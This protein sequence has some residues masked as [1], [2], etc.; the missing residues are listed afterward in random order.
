MARFVHLH[1]HTDLSL[2]DGACSIGAVLETCARH[3]M[4]AVAVT[5][6]GN[7][8]CAVDFYRAALKKSIR[9]IIGYEAYI[10][11]DSRR[12]R[13]GG[14]QDIRHLTLLARSSRGYKN[15]MRLA[16]CAYLEGFYYKPRI[17]YDLLAEASE[18]LIILSGCTKSDIAMRLLA[19]DHEGAERVA[20]RLMDMVGPEHFFIELQ[21]HGLDDEKAY[22]PAAVALARRLGVGLVATNDVHYISREDAEAQEV[23][24][25][26]NTGKVFSDENRMRLGTQEFYLKSPQE[27][28]AL[29][30]DLPEAVENTVRIAEMCHAE[31]DMNTTYL[32]RFRSDDGVDSDTLFRLLCEDGARRRYQDF[33]DDETLNK[34]LHH[35]MKVIHRMGFVDYF[36]VVWDFVR[37]AKANR[38][39]VGPGRGS[40]AGSMVAY[41]LGITDID[42]IRHGLLFERFLNPDRISLPDIDIDFSPEG[43]ERVIG[44]V[45]ERYG[46]DSV[47]QIITFGTLQARAAIRDVGR[48]LEIPLPQVDA[49]AKRIPP[50]TSLRKALK[51]GEDLRALA[52]DEV[53]AKLF[54]ISQRLEGLCRHASKHAAGVVIADGPLVE[55]SPLY[56][57]DG[58]IITQYA[59]GALE[60][61][62]LMKMDFLGLTTLDVIKHCTEALAADGEEVDLDGNDD[63]KTYDLLCRG[64]TKGVFQLESEGMR[65]LLTQ[66]KPRRFAE[67]V[68]VLALYRPGPMRSGMVQSYVKR[69]AGLE[70]IEYPHPSLREVLEDTYGVVLYQEQVMRIANILAGFSMSEADY[71][72]K[73]MGKKMMGIVEEHRE[74]FIEGAVARKVKKDLAE[75]IYDQLARFAEYGFNK[76]HSA[77]YAVLS[78]RTAYLK[79]NHPL[80]FTAALLSSEIGKSEKVAEYVNDCRESGLKLL[81]PDVNRSAADFRVDDGGVRYG[82][83]AIKGVGTKAAEVVVAE[84]EKNGSY[85][86]LWEFCERVDLRAVNRQVLDA[87]VKAGAMDG[88]GGHRAAL[89]AVLDRALQ[90]GQ[91]VQRDVRRGQ[92]ALFGGPG[93]A[94]DAPPPPLPDVPP[95][96]DVQ[97]MAWEKE[98]LGVYLADHPLQKHERLLSIFATHT[99][100][101]LSSAPDKH[102]VVLGVVLE[103]VLQRR[104]KRGDT[105]YQVQ[106]ADMTGGVGGVVFSRTAR[107]IGDMLKEDE[108]VFVVGSVDA[109]RDRPSVVVDSIIR[110]EEV[111]ERLNG[112]L[113]LR[114]VNEDDDSVKRLRRVLE[115]HRG[116]TVVRLIIRRDDAEYVIRLPSRFSVRPDESFFEALGRLDCVR[117]EF[118]RFA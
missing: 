69:R 60:A 97:R 87:L 34:R 23:L 106:M 2:L 79:A 70:P 90:A 52:E 94:L 59:M 64:D 5:D 95:P 37:F 43:R 56:R 22:E 20:R 14:Q 92:R 47:A 112:R 114:L 104:S 66:L 15:L 33:D 102:R 41:C 108:V 55:Y 100:S 105:Y 118:S 71:L 77:A 115:K 45:R 13:T 27:M 26:M 8:F 12:T 49:I 38:I 42:P 80:H 29:F 63:R 82:L 40:A 11:R 98:A 96:T 88:L 10:A 3:G 101:R 74:R 113:F 24:L 116:R 72:R 28:E 75:K 110:P 51:E 85:K 111:P 117:P 76:S 35:E 48:V 81:P 25:C 46:R 89:L 84:R 31:I 68:D 73:A 50:N 103:Q 16:S 7:M 61:I 53:F 21:R 30:S 18:G 54:A 62:G 32:P 107:E 4:K 44:Y 9:P 39:P 78:Y 58:E 83:A 109:A 6:H 36:L 17:D 99:V 19:G 57:I 65:D 86:S 93:A 1:L 67:L 91:S